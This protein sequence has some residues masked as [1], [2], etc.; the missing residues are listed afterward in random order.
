MEASVITAIDT[1]VTQV[2][3]S[4]SAITGWWV[5]GV[6]VAFFGASIAVNVVLSLFGKKRRKRK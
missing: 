4:F 5:I 3:G 1:A 6:A 2:T